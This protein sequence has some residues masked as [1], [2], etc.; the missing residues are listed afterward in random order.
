[1]TEDI[2]YNLLGLLLALL[3][4]VAEWCAGLLRW[5]YPQPEEVP[6]WSKE[7]TEA[8]AEYFERNDEYFENN[9]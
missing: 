7:V 5:E 2:S 3:F 6:E 1:V 9:D 4:G 8:G